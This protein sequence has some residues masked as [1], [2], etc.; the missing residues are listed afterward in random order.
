MSRERGDSRG[1]TLTTESERNVALYRHLGYEVV[2]RRPIAP[3]ME[4][5]GLWRPDYSGP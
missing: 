2:G 3:G 1:V 5:W 4:T